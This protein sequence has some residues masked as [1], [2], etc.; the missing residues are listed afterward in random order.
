MTD[1][2]LIQTNMERLSLNDNGWLQSTLKLR[3]TSI[4]Y[5]KRITDRAV[6]NMEC[7]HLQNK[8]IEEFTRWHLAPNG[9]TCPENRSRE[10]MVRSTD[11]A[12]ESSKPDGD[13]GRGQHTIFVLLETTMIGMFV[14]R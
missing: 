7:L 13:R 5:L 4:I 12:D 6:L 11:E 2:G 8:T 3:I 1:I 10:R 9:P 14:V